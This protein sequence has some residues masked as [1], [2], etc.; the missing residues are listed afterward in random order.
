M[1]SIYI[2][3]K[4]ILDQIWADLDKKYYRCDGV[5]C[6]EALSPGEGGV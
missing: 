1:K 6:G 2:A 4:D 3:V 5:I